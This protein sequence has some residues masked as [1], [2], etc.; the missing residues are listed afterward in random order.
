[1]SFEFKERHLKQYPHFDQLISKD[2]LTELVTS[3]K[4]VRPPMLE[5]T[6]TEKDAVTVA[7]ERCGLQP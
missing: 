1:M 3:P 5:L 6:E 4:R 7:F 2:A